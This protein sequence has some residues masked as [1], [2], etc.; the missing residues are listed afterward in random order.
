MVVGYTTPDPASAPTTENVG[1]AEVGH[2]NNAVFSAL[3]GGIT[4]FII[5]S[6]WCSQSA[7]AD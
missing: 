6:D 3:A 1:E 5:A 7:P 2:T 4:G